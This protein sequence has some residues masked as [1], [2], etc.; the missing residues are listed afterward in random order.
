[1]KE[2]VILAGGYGTRLK[3]VVSEV[4]KSMAQIGDHPFLYYLLVKL[5]RAGLKRII[6][7]VGY[8]ADSIQSF[9]G[10]SFNGIELVY[11]IEDEPLGT[12]GAIYRAMD[13]IENDWFFVINGDTFFDVDYDLMEKR[14]QMTEEGLILALKPMTDFERY[15]AVITD[16]DR[17]ISFNEK[18]HCSKG[19]INGGIYL[20]RK[21]WLNE[22]VPAARFS[23][24]KDILEKFVTTVKIGY[25]I[26]EGYFI[27][28]GIPEDY[29]KASL[30][31]PVLYS[32]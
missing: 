9:F 16:N 5:Q 21:E 15:G 3:S 31:L 27:D 14:F 24:E 17:I 30:D 22:R 23:F 28:I 12:G 8:L 7:A 25:F 26:S 18:K 19:L 20:I 2:A 1:M 10:D 6:L 13:S 32:R 11:S 4:P 29:R